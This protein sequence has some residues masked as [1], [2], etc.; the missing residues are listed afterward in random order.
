MGQEMEMNDMQ[1]GFVDKINEAVA[2]MN[3]TKGGYLGYLKMTYNYKN[4]NSISED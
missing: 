1:K 2:Y 3:K 4:G